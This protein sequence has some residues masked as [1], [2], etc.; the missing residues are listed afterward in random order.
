MSQKDYYALLGVDRDASEADIKKAFRRKARE[1]HPDVA[2]HDG[3]EDAFKAVNEAYEVL[4]DPE[5]R[6]MY[7]RYGTADPRAAGPDIGD[8]FGGGGI[9]MDDIFS[10]FFGGG[11]GGGSQRPRTGGRDMT[12][13]VTI[14]LEEAATGV[15][16]TLRVTRDAPCDTCGATGAADGGTARTC[17]DCGGTG[18]RR[19]GRRTFLGVVESVTP[20]TTCGATGAVIDTPCAVCN[21]SGRARVTSDIEVTVPPG[22]ENGMRIHVPGAGEAG[23]R[24]AQAGS[25]LVTVRVQPHEFLHR[26]ADDLHVRAS[27]SVAQAALGT[28][29]HVPG[30]QGDVKVDVDGGAQFGDTIRVRGE[31][32]PRLREAG[33]GTGRGDL[34]V[35]VAIEV[36]RKLSKRQRE[37][38]AELGETFGDPERETPMQRLRDWLSS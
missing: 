1:T 16:K 10:A 32:M 5:R 25:L 15:T 26:D 7:D 24:G 38:M 30:L 11:F 36:P 29:L 8:I 4:C 19:V 13:A 14:T 34:Y 22:A 9:G 2:S 20:C 27:L 17:A 35:H 6:R 21:G 33:R 18:Q 3:A 37:L 28:T 23:I 12:A 31:G